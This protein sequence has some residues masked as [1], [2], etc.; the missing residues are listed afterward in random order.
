LLQG[1]GKKPPPRSSI[2]SK[3]AKIV[4]YSENGII[5][6]TIRFLIKRMEQADL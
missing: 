2:L 5:A 3:E 6:D 1:G 4:F